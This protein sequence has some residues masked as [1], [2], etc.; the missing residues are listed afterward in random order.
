MKNFFSTNFAVKI[1]NSDF[2][3]IRKFRSL[4]MKWVY[5]D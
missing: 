4:T 1:R 5:V 3:T 2:V